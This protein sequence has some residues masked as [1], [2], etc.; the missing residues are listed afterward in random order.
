MAFVQKCS[1]QVYIKIFVLKSKM[2]T[3]GL[4]KKFRFEVKNY[5]KNTRSSAKA[6][7]VKSVFAV[8]ITL[9]LS[10]KRLGS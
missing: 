2:F 4:H 3:A 10:S 5:I 9:I 8:G 7:L 6:S 1:L